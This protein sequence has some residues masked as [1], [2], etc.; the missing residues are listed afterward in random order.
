MH[1]FRGPALVTLGVVML[2]CMAAWN[3]GRARV[4]HGIMAPATS[5]HPEFE[6][7]FRVQMNT[8]ENSLMFLPPLWLFAAFVNEIWA[9]GI[10]V[11]WLAARVW[12]SLAYQKAPAL[13]RAPFVLSTL[14][15]AALM[16]GA[17]WGVLRTFF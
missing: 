1:D 15:I 4:K 9:A 7:A 6:R 13:R 2:L 8:L 17:G 16:L 10:G 5:G 12:Y 11:V 3:V 14:A